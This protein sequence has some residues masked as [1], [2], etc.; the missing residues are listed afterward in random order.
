MSADN[1]IYI[2]QHQDEYRVAE[3]SNVDDIDDLQIGKYYQV[4]CFE[5]APVF[6]SIDDATEYAYKLAKET[7]TEYGVCSISKKDYPF[8]TFTRKEAFVLITLESIKSRGFVD[9][10][11]KVA[12]SF[13]DNG[14]EASFYTE[15]HIDFRKGDVILSFKKR[16]WPGV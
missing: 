9:D 4:L 1:G 11:L 7:Y 12:K 15:H 14:F 3:F 13:L 10:E 5:G 8:P 16:I 6:S 2:I